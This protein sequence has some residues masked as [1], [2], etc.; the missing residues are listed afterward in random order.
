M[1]DSSLETLFARASALHPDIRL[2][3]PAFAL[4]IYTKSMGVPTRNDEMRQDMEVSRYGGLEVRSD[5]MNTK[6]EREAMKDGM[7][8]RSKEPWLRHSYAIP[9]NWLLRR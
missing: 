5:V 3:G 1:V 8:A 4:D 9:P 7:H 2:R 6:G